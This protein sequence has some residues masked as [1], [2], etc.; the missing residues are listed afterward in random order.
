[1]ILDNDSYKLFENIPNK[2]SNIQTY[3]NQLHNKQKE[4]DK[5]SKQIKN[6][7]SLASSLGENKSMKEISDE[8]AN[9]SKKKDRITEDIQ[10]LEKK[11]RHE[12]SGS[13]DELLKKN[14]EVL[15]SISEKFD[16]IS[17][18]DAIKKITHELIESIS[19]LFVSEDNYY[20]IEIML[21]G[22]E[23][24]IKAHT[25]KNSDWWVISGSK[26]NTD[27][28]DFDL[29]NSLKANGIGIEMI[30][31]LIY[32]YDKHIPKEKYFN[33]N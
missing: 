29:P 17:N 10:E 26:S 7:I 31:E 13:F 14:S 18:F 12:S 3:S 1:M 24:P 6:L 33:F 22:K 30:E 16:N 20:Y 28:N 9:F 2:E 32:R 23:N 5:I 25:D 19:V 15:N 27:I 4:L 21:K 11:I 8:L